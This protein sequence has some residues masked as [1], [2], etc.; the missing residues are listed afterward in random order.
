MLAET[1]GIALSPAGSGRFLQGS[2]HVAFGTPSVINLLF[3]SLGVAGL[4]ADRL[5]TG[6]ALG[7][8]RPHLIDVQDDTVG[9]RF[10]SQAFERP[11]FC[12]NSGSSRSPN[13][14]SCLRQRKPSSCRISKMR[15]F[16]IE[17]PNCSFA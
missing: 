5:L 3:G 12:A 4:H 13:Q 15:V 9:W 1:P 11:L 10:P 8:D 16:F 7:G 17:R 14:V 2:I 6:I